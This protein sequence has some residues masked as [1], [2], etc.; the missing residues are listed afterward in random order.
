LQVF[1]DIGHPWTRLW[2]TICTLIGDD[3]WNIVV[4]ISPIVFNLLYW[5]VGAILFSFNFIPW[6][7]KYKIQPEQKVDV[8]KCLKVSGEAI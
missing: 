8:Q 3:Q 5:V 1:F 2:V 4:W 7:Q 6:F